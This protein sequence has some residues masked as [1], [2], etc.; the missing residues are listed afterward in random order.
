MA[1]RLVLAIALAAS[2]GL[3]SAPVRAYVVTCTNCSDTWTQAAERITSLEELQTTIKQY[4][5]AIAQTQQQIALVQNNIKQYENMIQNTKTLPQ[6][7]LATLKTVLGN[8]ADQTIQL[9][10]QKG[11]YMALGELFDS[12]YP[13]AD[14]IKGLAGNSNASMDELWDK[15]TREADRATQATFQ[16][17]G[18]QLQDL[19]QNSDAL[20]DH[21]SQLLSTPEGQM[22]AISAGNQLASI[23]IAEAQKL[24]SLMATSIQGDAQAAAESEKEKQLVRENWKKMNTVPDYWKE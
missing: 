2:L 13:G 16:L 5:E 18:M 17:S 1:K 21:I 6:Q 20:S 3:A 7:L 9:N 8:L 14:I 12:I 19:A 15:W 10:I 23:Q 24:R 11:D 4:Q 22:E